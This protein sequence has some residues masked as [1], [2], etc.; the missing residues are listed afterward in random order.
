[1]RWTKFSLGMVLCMAM[2]LGGCAPRVV[3][4]PPTKYCDLLKLQVRLANK[5]R[6]EGTQVIQIG[7]ETTLILPADKFFYPRSNNMRPGYQPHLNTIIR[8]I[9]TYP[10]TDV[11]VT[12]YTDNIGDYTRNMALSRAQAQ[13]IVN[14]LWS[15]GLNTRM[16]SASGKGCHDDIANNNTR[17]GNAL[18]RR[19]EIYFRLPP[20]AN[21]FH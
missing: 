3:Y 4:P 19:I 12:G 21:V 16:I 2:L 1:M 20:P 9:N 10:T 5:L 18:N 17:H 14:Y 7:E 13:A 11:Q 15:H 8:F 6:A